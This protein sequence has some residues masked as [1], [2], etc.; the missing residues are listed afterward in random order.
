MGIVELE[1]S[2]DFHR[3]PVFPSRSGV[4]HDVS[5]RRAVANCRRAILGEPPLNLIRADERML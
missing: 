5:L 2:G 4:W 1:A 3:V